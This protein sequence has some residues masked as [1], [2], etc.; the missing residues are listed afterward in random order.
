MHCA[1]DEAE[2]LAWQAGGGGEAPPAPN[3]AVFVCFF[4]IYLGKLF[5][6]LNERQQVHARE[7]ADQRVHIRGLQERPVRNVDEQGSACAAWPAMVPRQR[8]SH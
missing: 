7:D 6:L 8:R 1:S 5:D 2:P 4:E 3:K